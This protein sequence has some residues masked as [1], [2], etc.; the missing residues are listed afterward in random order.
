MRRIRR[1]HRLA[2]AIA[3]AALVVAA[4]GGDEEAA[5]PAETE[6]APAEE[7]PAEEAP[8][9][10]EEAPA[11]EEPDEILTDVGVT[12]EPCPNAV[13]EDN[14][15][16]YLGVLSDLTEGPFA[17]LAVEIVAAQEAFFQR[18][19]EEGG[20]GGYDINI[21]EYTRDTRYDPAE[22]S[23]AYRQIE[24]DIL[25]LA[26]SLGTPPT[27]AILPEMDADDMVAMPA[28]WWSGW[29]FADVDRGLILN[30]GY[31]YC[32][33]AMI[34]LDWM[35]ENAG[36]INSV[37]A[38]GYPGDYG[39]D[40]AAG[41][42]LWAE[43]NDAEFIGFVETGPNYI[44]GSQDG[45]IG[46]VLGSGAD[47]VLLAVGPAETA[48]IVGGSAANDFTSPFLG[49]VPTWNSALL[50]TA[51]APALEALYTWIG[52][53]ENFLGESEGH[54]AMQDSLG[55]EMPGNEGYTAGW[56]WSYPVKAVLEAAAANGDLTRAGVRA[57]AD[58]LVVDYEGALP[59]RV[60]GGDA[61]EDAPRSAVISQPDPDAE[62]GITTIETNV[63]GPT[64]DAHDYSGPCVGG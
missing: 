61:N 3:V 58:G 29:D 55:G 24:P 50:Q 7:A 34:G 56:I 40:F 4:C 57:A 37:L 59:D 46:Q 17:A 19:N 60:Y 8:A 47:I 38:V 26:Q 1:R 53:W 36:E 54:Q 31:S 45:A 11:A 23:T 25:M 30:S 39:G 12:E 2:A 6:E 5:A 43:A 63:T 42:E 51:A 64:A 33:E 18:V 9:E 15:C 14:G 52:P 48:E 27:E 32:M 44:V 16:I 41:A 62:L 20:I 49:S 35:N 28:T 10:T 21:T 13:N 22:H